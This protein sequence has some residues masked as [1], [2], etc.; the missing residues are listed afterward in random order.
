MIIGVSP[1]SRPTEA[2]TIAR[3][4]KAIGIM[5]T[6]TSDILFDGVAIPADSPAVNLPPVTGGE[7]PALT[8]DPQASTI[9]LI[10]VR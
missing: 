8:Y 2:G 4:A 9:I 1:I 7:Y 5:N 6:G 3:G 10:V